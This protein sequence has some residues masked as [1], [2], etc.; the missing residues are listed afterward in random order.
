MNDFANAEVF[1][2]RSGLVLTV[3][4]AGH[5][6]PVLLLHGSGGPAT[7]N[8]LVA[9]LAAGRRVLAPT[10]PGWDGTTRPDDLASVA[11]LAAVYLDLLG[12]QGLTGVTV[13][14]ASLGGWIAAE[15]AVAD[16]D[17]RI[18]RL[19]LID[20]LGPRIPGHQIAMPS[21]LPPANLAALRAYVG[22]SLED[23]V[24]LDRVQAL[25]IPTFL[26]WGEDDGFQTVDYAERYAREIPQT[27]LVRIKSAGHIPMENDP[28]AV[29]GALAKFFAAER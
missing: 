10:H 9:H 18:G 14:G 21:T 20:A 22:D 6:D 4:K 25:T 8:P 11:G 7:I 5:G 26:V 15:M 17:H 28:K 27:R 12:Q 24:L 29:A 23:P 2:I 13:V 16:R 3:H 19:I 1:Q